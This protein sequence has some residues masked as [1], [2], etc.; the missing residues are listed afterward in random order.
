M[1]AEDLVKLIEEMIDLKIRQHSAA[2]AATS[3]GNGKPAP[4]LARV[5]VETKFADRQRLE[6]IKD[7]LARMIEA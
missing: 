2:T 5:I 6:Q 4:N 3:N 1:P 7:E